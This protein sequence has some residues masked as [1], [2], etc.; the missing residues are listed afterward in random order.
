[1][2]V[3]HCFNS[4]A[5]FVP[6]SHAASQIPDAATL[7]VQ[8]RIPPT[9]LPVLASYTAEVKAAV[10]FSDRSPVDK[11]PALYPRVHFCSA[12]CQA[13]NELLC[14]SYSP[15]GSECAA[16]GLA[17]RLV[18]WLGMRAVDFWLWPAP[19]RLLLLP[20]FLPPLRRLT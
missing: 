1:M 9:S 12:L 4:P 17:W 2:L 13:N 19:S 11:R 15:G 14:A 10:I 18:R 8:R 6:L 7:H 3:P 5:P 20:V 16:G